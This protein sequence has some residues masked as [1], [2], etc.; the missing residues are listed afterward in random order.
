ML[1]VKCIKR[2][3]LKSGNSGSSGSSGNSGSSC[4]SGNS[5][6]SCNSGNSCSSCSV[7]YFVNFFNEFMN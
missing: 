7:T 1:S 2:S 3:L 5:G 4:N 6:S